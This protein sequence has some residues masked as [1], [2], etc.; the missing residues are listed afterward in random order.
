VLKRGGAWAWLVVLAFGAVYAASLTFVYIE[1]DD[2]RS[3]AY[4]AYGRDASAIGP[5]AAYQAGMDALLRWLPP[6]EP[7]LRVT[8]MSATAAAGALMAVLLLAVAFGW[9]GDLT[10]REKLAAAGAT[11]LAMPELFYLSLVYQPPLV[12]MCCALG[13]HLTLWR[14]LREGS[15][16]W[17]AVSCA[18]FAAAGVFRWNLLLYGWVVAADLLFRSE[19]DRRAREALLAR[20]LATSLGLWALGSAAL[21]AGWSDV[22][23]FVRLAETGASAE[24]G[25]MTAVAWHQ[26]LLTPGLLALGVIGWRALRSMDT[27]AARA[28]VFGAAP[29][30]FLLPTENP[31]QELPFLAPVVALAACGAVRCLRGGGWR[32]ATVSAV[33]LLP[34]VVG[35]RV[36]SPETG[37]GGSFAVPDYRTPPAT[38]WSVRVAWWSGGAV[39][40]QEGPR[41]LWGNGH[42]LLGGG[43]RGLVT[44]AAR[45][46]QRAWRLAAEEKLPVVL[47]GI[48]PHYMAAE[49]AGTGFARSA[50]LVRHLSDEI[51][52]V[53]LKDGHAVRAISLWRGNRSWVSDDAAPLRTATRGQDFVAVG[54]ARPMR[55]MAAL[56]GLELRALGPRSALGRW[57]PDK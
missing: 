48:A 12:G 56:P 35:F 14:A 17:W 51:L 50:D 46:R 45:E 31:K 20:W 44:E 52:T 4:H 8:A 38:R 29:L 9:V 39:A 16:R 19:E 24:R 22:V 26:P 28:A 1:G 6:S 47:L 36:V 23:A 34:W 25:W 30:L 42:A 13:A 2:A 41:G 10:G 15:R 18:L 3:I 21:G 11:L 40:T 57:H 43:W 37:W 32:I 33:L 55:A 7:V 27:G 49:M 5:Y 53:R 54:L